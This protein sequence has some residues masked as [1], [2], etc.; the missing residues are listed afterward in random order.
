MNITNTLPRFSYLGLLIS[1]VFFFCVAPFFSAG[2]HARLVLDLSI[3][4]ILILSVYM[5]SDS[6]RNVVIASVLASPALLRM[7]YPTLLVDEISLAFNALFFGFV[8]F[9]L[10]QKIFHTYR[11]NT[12]ILFAAIAVYMLIGFFWGVVYTLLEFY[13]PGSFSLEP[14]HGGLGFYSE[15]AQDLIYYSFVSLTTLGYGDITSLSKPAKFFSVLEAMM[16]QVYLTVLVAH[17]VGMHIAGV[18]VRK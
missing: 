16:G 1:L 2:A 11:V 6:V 12:D 17:L 10:L 7:I 15:T 4:V 18:E 13:L 5:C 3:L 14:G 8:I 9:E